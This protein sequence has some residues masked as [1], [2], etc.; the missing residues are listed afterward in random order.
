MRE[1]EPFDVASRI[2]GNTS[3]SRDEEVVRNWGLKWG[4]EGF[5]QAD[6]ARVGG[7]TRR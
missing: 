6:R 3:Q 1:G 2:F 7:C 5:L 4:E